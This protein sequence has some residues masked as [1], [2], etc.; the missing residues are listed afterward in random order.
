MAGLDGV[1][2]DI[3]CLGDGTLVIHH[4]LYLAGGPSLLTLNAKSLPAEIPTLIQTLAWAAD[5]GAYLNLEFKFEGLKVDDRVARTLHLLRG[6]GLSKQSIV[7]SFQPMM[8]KA[9]QATASEIERGLLTYRAYQLGTIDLV[10]F[11]MRWA[12]CTALHAMHTTINPQLMAQAK[13]QHWR[14]NA[15]TVNEVSE[16]SRLVGLGV[17]GLIGDIPEVLLM[18]RGGN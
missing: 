1:E 10:P 13:A 9:A 15:W 16:V 5:T 17:H 11:V 18:A 8:L 4:D 2:L 7:S 6:F 14:I 12:D 3:Q